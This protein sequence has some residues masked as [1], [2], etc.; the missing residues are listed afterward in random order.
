[1]FLPLGFFDPGRTCVLLTNGNVK[2]IIIM[3][4]FLSDFKDFA[5]KGN[6]VDM[7]VGVIIGGAFGK[8]VSSLVNDILMPCFSIFGSG[9]GIKQLK[10]V[11]V[12]GQAAQDGAAAV[13]EVAINYG[14]FI[15][16][17]VDFLII[18]LSIFVALRVVF[19]FMK[20]EKKAEEAP[21]PPA[22][23]PEETLLTEIRDLIKERK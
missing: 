7:A 8:I 5:M 4:K 10:Y 22:P 9:D 19:K 13:E 12:L 15:M 17:I 2:S 21:A 14:V 11:I 1:M 18:A 3:G 20:K 23:T 6:I 16:N